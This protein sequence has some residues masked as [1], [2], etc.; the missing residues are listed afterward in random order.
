MN[1]YTI[2]IIT[3]LFDLIFTYVGIKKQT[4]IR[5]GPCSKNER[6]AQRAPP[7][8]WSVSTVRLAANETDGEKMLQ[9]AADWLANSALNTDVKNNP[10]HLLSKWTE[11]CDGSLFSERCWNTAGNEPDDSQTPMKVTKQVRL[12]TVEIDDR[13]QQ[14]FA[15]QTTSKHAPCTHM[16]HRS[17]KFF[18]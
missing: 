5:S 18:N 10:C 4:R 13:K 17:G 3:H 1:R 2:V 8:W 9:T 16:Q 15:F 12:W 7:V 11:R 14:V 6:A